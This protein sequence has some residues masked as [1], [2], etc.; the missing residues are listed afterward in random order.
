MET[1]QTAY[2]L[3]YTEELSGMFQ[4]DLFCMLTRTGSF[5]VLWTFFGSCRRSF[6]GLYCSQ[7]R[8]RHIGTSPLGLLV[9]NYLISVIFGDVKVNCSLLCEAIVQLN[10]PWIERCASVARTDMT[11]RAG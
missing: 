3:M 2:S 6:T 4:F 11:Q 9:C 10:A 7:N 1:S 8:L 5:V